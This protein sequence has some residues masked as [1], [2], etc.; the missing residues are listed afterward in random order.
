MTI[1]L[2][3]VRPFGTYAK[4]DVIGDAASIAAISAS[5]QA[6]CVVRV[7]PAAQTLTVIPTTTPTSTQPQQGA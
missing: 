4:G 1:Q 2:V 7:R 3:V 5:E 6:T